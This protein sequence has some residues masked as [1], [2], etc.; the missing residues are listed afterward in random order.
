MDLNLLAK[1][2][3]DINS[4]LTYVSSFMCIIMCVIWFKILARIDICMKIIQARDA[5]LDVEVQFNDQ[6]L[7]VHR[8][9][10][11]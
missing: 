8:V 3:H 4:A 1:A 7:Y 9:S 5:T 6:R 10:D 11:H 2:R